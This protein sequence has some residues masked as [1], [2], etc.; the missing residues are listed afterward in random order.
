[1]LLALLILAVNVQARPGQQ[2]AREAAR[3]TTPA[4]RAWLPQCRVAEPIERDGFLSRQVN[5]DAS[6]ANLWGDAAN[7]PTIA[8]DPAAPNRIVIAWRQFDSIDS[9]FRKAGYAYSLDGGRTWSFPGTLDLR[10]RS[11]PVLASDDRG[12][13]HLVTLLPSMRCQL[14]SSADGGQTWSA[15]VAA[16]GGDKPWLAVDSSLGPGNGN[17]YLSW[18][19]ST[20]SER[21][22]I[23][24]RSTDGG[25]SFHEPYRLHPPLSWGTIAIGPGSEVYVAGVLPTGALAAARSDNAW[26]STPTFRH[27]EVDLGGL[28]WSGAD[29]NPDGLSGQVWIATDT[30]G[31]PFH[32]NVYLLC[33]IMPMPPIGLIGVRFARSED[34]GETWS[35]AIT[36]APREHATWQWFG[37]MSVAPDGRIDAVWIEALSGEQAKLGEIHY[38]CSHDAGATWAASVAVTPVFDSHLGWPQQSKMGDYFHMRSDLLGADL[39][40]AA[41]FNGEQDI[42]HLRIGERDCNRNRI[43]D[44]WEIS[45]AEVS[46]CNRNLIPDECE[47]AAGAI[48]DS[49]EDGTPD[50]CVLEPR[51]V[52]GRHS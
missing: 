31:G 28:L 20:S 14:S 45:A 40:Y 19:D 7:E 27:A 10:F 33:S 22:R 44:R 12:R 18:I 37:T 41:T 17:L 29:P 36:V 1:L 47:V 24:T 49:N 2:D 42:Y 50:I 21:D 30:S 9:D 46:D 38:T 4:D 5:V 51:R 6:G 15:P 48:A 13:F 26:S 11:D 16:Y 25:Q 52:R 34:G 43:S 35:E 3:V 8:I 39:A 23:F 32:G